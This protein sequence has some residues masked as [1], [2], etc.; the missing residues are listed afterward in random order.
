MWIRTT[1]ASFSFA[2]LLACA[3]SPTGPSV[4]GDGNSSV[5]IS[6]ISPAAGEV[7]ARGFG[8]VA[9]TY[10]LDTEAQNP[11]VWTCLG[12]TPDSVVLSSCRSVAV[13]AAAGT[14]ATTTGIYWVNGQPGARETTFVATFL[15]DGDIVERR[16]DV[17]PF[18]LSYRALT[19]RRLAQETRPHVW[20]WAERP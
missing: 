9:V 18:E 15:I 19:L 2:S 17:P 11:R 16:L 4:T 14:V 7:V 20:R 5:V 10:R 6:V 3:V 12:R 13:L 1:V 8:E